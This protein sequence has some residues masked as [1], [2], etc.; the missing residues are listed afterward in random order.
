MN[1]LKSLEENSILIIPASLRNKVLKYF[2][3]EL[4]FNNVKII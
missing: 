1:I 3:D 2:N 4:I